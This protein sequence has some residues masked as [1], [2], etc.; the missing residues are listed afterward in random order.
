VNYIDSNNS[1]H[2][3]V[4]YID[5]QGEIIK[6]LILDTTETRDE[7]CTESSGGLIAVP[8]ANAKISNGGIKN[9]RYGYMNHQGKIVISPRYISAGKF[10]EGLASVISWSGV[11]NEITEGGYINKKGKLAIPLNNDWSKPGEFHE[12]LASVLVRVPWGS[13]N[14][15]S[16][17][18]VPTSNSAYSF[19]RDRNSGVE[20]K[21]LDK[22]SS[23][24]ARSRMFQEDCGYINHEGVFVI[25]HTLNSCTDFH[26]GLAVVSDES[27]YHPEPRI[28]IGHINKKGRLLHPVQVE[29]FSGEPFKEG[30]ALFT[31][32]ELNGNYCYM[33]RQGRTVIS[34]LRLN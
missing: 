3:E 34:S 13:T 8:V 5:R 28:F 20:L 21:L 19:Q 27:Y 31:K 24:I 11:S 32:N 16:S 2:V 4:Q 17:P 29:Y 18:T 33:N 1:K 30:L 14:P 25:K 7:P 23:R 10:S 15:N 6:Q 9:Y 12:G 26:E 22:I